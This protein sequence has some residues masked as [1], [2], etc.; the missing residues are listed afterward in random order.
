MVTI[1]VNQAS[2]LA[3]VVKTRS[4]NILHISHLRPLTAEIT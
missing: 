3:M 1:F 4:R 2:K